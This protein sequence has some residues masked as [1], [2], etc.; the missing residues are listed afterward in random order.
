MILSLDRKCSERHE[1]YTTAL[2]APASPQEATNKSVLESTPRSR[3]VPRSGGRCTIQSGLL[4]VALHLKGVS[5]GENFNIHHPSTHPQPF[6]S[7]ACR[8]SNVCGRVSLGTLPSV[9]IAGAEPCE[10]LN[11]P[12][13][14]P[15]NCSLTTHRLCRSWILVFDSL[16]PRSAHKTAP[17]PRCLPGNSGTH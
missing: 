10:S 13:P 8:Q 9:A 14:P 16:P 4:Q 1:T 7:A 17:A 5:S 12:P 2:G 15:K 11:E 3:L 6:P